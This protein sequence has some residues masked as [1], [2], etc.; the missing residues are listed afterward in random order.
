MKIFIFATLFFFWFATPARAQVVISEVYPAP[1]S[2]EKEWIELYNTSESSVDI[3]GWKLFEHFSSKS[4]LVTFINAQI[5]PHGFFVLELTSNKL[6]NTEEKISLENTQLEEQ[7]VLHFTNSETQMSFSFLF[8]DETTIS[9]TL[10]ITQPTKGIKNPALAIQTPTPLPT[11]S[12]V[13]QPTTTV[14]PT[15]N[16]PKQSLQEN[17]KSE[18]TKELTEIDSNVDPKPTQIESYRKISQLLKL[19]SYLRVEKVGLEKRVPQLSYLIQKKVSKQGVIN[20]IIGG[21][22]LVCTGLLL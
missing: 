14:T 11:P 10:E 8:S 20:A 15:P 18:A 9:D 7:N 6:N 2:E 13:P 16:P 22:L 1:T 19:P 3:S 5:E 21:T 4:E 12:T 17:S